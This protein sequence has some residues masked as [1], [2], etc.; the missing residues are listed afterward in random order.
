MV[1]Y[2]V[3][4]GIWCSKLIEPVQVSRE[5]AISVWIDDYRYP[6]NSNYEAYFDTLNEAKTFLTKYAENAVCAAQS[7]LKVVLEFS[8]RVKDLK[9][10]K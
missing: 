2:K 7:S 4:K 8:K 6:K 10:G 9:E 3:N 5:T 1:K